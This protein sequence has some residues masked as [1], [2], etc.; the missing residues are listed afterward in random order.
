[1]LQSLSIKNYALIQQ[2]YLEPAGA[3][4]IITGETGAGKSILL[5]ALGLLMGRRAD[6]QVL[7]DKNSKCIIEGTFRVTDYEL[8]DFFQGCEIEYDPETIIRR[9]IS[10]TGKSRAFINDT[11]VT[12]DIL[13]SLSVQLMDIHSQHE[14]LQLSQHDFQVHLLDAFAGVLNQQKEFSLSYDKFR[15]ARKKLSDLREQQIEMEKEAD[16][17]HFILQELQEANL[18]ASETEDLEQVRKRA[19]HA[20]EIKSTLGM[21]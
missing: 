12:L 14:T 16:Y 6:T 1:M 3:L 8:R 10:P 19:E 20:E 9:E 18:D 2:L 5:G 4:N 7:F 13:R 15:K 21:L 11:P 17:R